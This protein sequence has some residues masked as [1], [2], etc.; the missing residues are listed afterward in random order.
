MKQTNCTRLLRNWI[1]ILISCTLIGILLDITFAD[2]E[3]KKDNSP[4]IE[5]S[6]AP[7]SSEEKVRKSAFDSIR[8]EYLISRDFN[9]DSI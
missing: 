5:G 3:S 7:N 9:P 1:L 6:P 8:N 2:T 4:A